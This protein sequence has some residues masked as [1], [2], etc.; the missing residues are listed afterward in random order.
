MPCAEIPIIIAC[1]L[2]VQF[3]SIPFNS[4]QSGSVKCGSFLGT[5]ISQPTCKL[6]KMF[7]LSTYGTSSR[8]SSL[9]RSE[10]VDWWL[11]GRGYRGQGRVL[12]YLL[13]DDNSLK[14]A[15]EFSRRIQLKNARCTRRQRFFCSNWIRKSNRYLI[16]IESTNLKCKY[17]KNNSNNKTR[18]TTCTAR[19]KWKFVDARALKSRRVLIRQSKCLFVFLPRFDSIF[20]YH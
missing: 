15:G 8:R 14:R 18:I 5:L 3:C 10:R 2:F 20:F 7:K 1:S 12:G 16:Q 13:L 11:M 4:V 9:R 17:S 6:C 19:A